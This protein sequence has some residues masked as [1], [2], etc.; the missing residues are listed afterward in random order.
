MSVGSPKKPSTRSAKRAGPDLVSSPHDRVFAF[1]FGQKVHAIGLLRATLPPALVARLDW[2]TLARQP[3]DFV[4]ARL[5]RRQSDLLF[6]IRTA[7]TGEEVLVYVLLE[8]Q[9]APDAKMAYRRA[10]LC[11]AHLG[12]PGD[13]APPP[14]PP[15][16]STRRTGLAARRLPAF[17]S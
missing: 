17:S 11:R 5:R 8:H 16:L 1:T 12:G 14:C 7:D 10:P 2:S 13:R 3:A 6:S 9:R 4:D 15:G